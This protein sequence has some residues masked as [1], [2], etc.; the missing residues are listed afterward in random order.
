MADSTVSEMHFP[1]RS[2]LYQCTMC[3]AVFD[4]EGRY[5]DGYEPGEVEFVPLDDECPEC[6][7][8]EIETI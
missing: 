5:R 6:G 4:C 1:A 8:T 2:V 7:S 3:V